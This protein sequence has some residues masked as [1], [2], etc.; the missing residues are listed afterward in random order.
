MG[1]RALV[2]ELCRDFRFRSARQM[3]LPFDA[4]RLLTLLR[5]ACAYLSKKLSKPLMDVR[6]FVSMVLRTLAVSKGLKQD[7]VS[8]STHEVSLACLC[9]SVDS[10]TLHGGTNTNTQDR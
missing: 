3:I 2:F 10:A 9:L 4:L 8:G 1:W 6:D 5:K 7:T